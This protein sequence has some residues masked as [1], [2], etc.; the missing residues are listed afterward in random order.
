MIKANRSFLARLWHDLSVGLCVM[1]RMQFS[2]PWRRNAE[3]LLGP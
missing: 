3:G 1:H 2:A